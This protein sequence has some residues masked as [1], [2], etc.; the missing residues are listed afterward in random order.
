MMPSHLGSPAFGVF[1]K[2]ARVGR[3]SL[4][5]PGLGRWESEM[6]EGS[7]QL[8]KWL[9]QMMSSALSGISS[10]VSKRTSLKKGRVT[11]SAVC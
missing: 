4:A 9:C 11:E 8:A 1:I 2:L 7:S 10:F 6:A 3:A 5:L